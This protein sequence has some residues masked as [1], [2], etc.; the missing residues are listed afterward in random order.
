MRLSFKEFLNEAAFKA[1]EFTKKISKKEKDGEESITYGKAVINKLVN[2]ESVKLGKDGKAGEFDIRGL[3]DDLRRK[4]ESLNTESPNNDKDLKS[5]K[6]SD[7]K[8]AVEIF[9]LIINGID[10]DSDPDKN[11]TNGN[12]IGKKPPKN[13]WTNIF[14]GDF[15]GN[16]EGPSTKGHNFEEEFLEM[17]N[18]GIAAEKAKDSVSKEFE[19]LK[20]VIGKDVEIIGVDHDGGNNTKRPFNFDGKK[21]WIGDDPSAANGPLDIGKVVSDITVTTSK[22][23]VYLSLK[24]GSTNAI[25]NLGVGS[26]FPKSFFEGKTRLSDGGRALFKCLHI[27]EEKFKETF[28]S[29]TKTKADKTKSVR[30][31][32][33]ELKPNTDDEEIVDNFTSELRNDPDFNNL[34]L[35]AFGF[36]YILVHK[37]GGKNGEISYRDFRKKETVSNFIKDDNRSKIEKAQVLYGGKSGDGKRVQVEI[38]Y[39]NVLDLSVVI[40]NVQGKVYPDKLQIIYKFRPEQILKS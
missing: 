36:G 25:L 38:N 7:Q 12:P 20:S 2:G 22:G 26:L 21:I 28:V 30:N 3:S 17:I 14:K 18:A 32:N 23:P 35:Q 11:N 10:P 8:S 39:G 6:K 37:S 24:F 5:D 40:R 15:S 31:K 16:P 13:R 4:L 33:P 29:Y 1:E 27:D 34:I 9:D 19:Q